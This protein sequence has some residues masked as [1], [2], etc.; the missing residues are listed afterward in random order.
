LT[1]KHISTSCKYFKDCALGWDCLIEITLQGFTVWSVQVCYDLIHLVEMGLVELV[2]NHSFVENKVRRGMFFTFREEDK[3]SDV[4]PVRERG[5]DPVL[6]G[7]GARVEGQQGGARIRLR[8][9][10]AQEG[11][12]DM[13]NNL[14]TFPLKASFAAMQWKIDFEEE[15]RSMK[16]Q[17]KTKPC[18][19]L[20][21]QILGDE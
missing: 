19:K 6:H 3:K 8:Q 15:L 12:K 21:D 18:W 11:G 9:L 5:G 17:I 7:Q 13:K 4:S 10:R 1:E 2:N 20:I 16:C 14:K